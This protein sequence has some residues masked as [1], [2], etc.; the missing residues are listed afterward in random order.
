MRDA[1]PVKHFLLLLCTNAIVLV[2]KVQEWALRLLQRSICARLQVAQIREYALFELFRV[3]DRAAKRLEAECKASYD[4]S[5]RDVE[6]V[7]PV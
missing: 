1:V 2:Q 6:E 7:V 5:A 4:I 3:L